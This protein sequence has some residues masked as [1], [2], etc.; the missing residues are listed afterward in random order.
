[1]IHIFGAYSAGSDEGFSYDQISRLELFG[2][3]PFCCSWRGADGVGSKLVAISLLFCS[4][5]GS[6]AVILGLMTLG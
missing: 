3:W 6:R 4:M 5:L 2:S 1:G